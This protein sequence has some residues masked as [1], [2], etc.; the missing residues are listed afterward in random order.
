MSVG[1][2]GGTHSDVSQD[3]RYV[4]YRDKNKA[5]MDILSGVRPGLTLIFV[6]TKR[7]CDTLDNFLYGQ[8]YVT[9]LSL[10]FY[11]T[12]L[13]FHYNPTF[14]HYNATFPLQCYFFP[15]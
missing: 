7:M 15:L 8:G 5:L 11:I 14:P 6:E 2:V 13:L 1:R 3:I 4:E 10:L 9:P 12:M